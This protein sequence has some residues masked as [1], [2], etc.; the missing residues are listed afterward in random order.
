MVPVIKLNVFKLCHSLN[1]VSQIAIVTA[2]NPIPTSPLVM[3]AHAAKA[4]ISHKVMVR[5]VPYGNLVANRNEQRDAVIKNVKVTSRVTTRDKANTKA[6]VA[7]IMLEIS[8]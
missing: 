1:M 3:S 8:P 2:K 4:Y 6:E 7:N 5:L